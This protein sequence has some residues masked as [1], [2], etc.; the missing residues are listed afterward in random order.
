MKC[1]VLGEKG[2]TWVFGKEG[3]MDEAPGVI[4]G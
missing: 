4:S 1:P 3:P 2:W